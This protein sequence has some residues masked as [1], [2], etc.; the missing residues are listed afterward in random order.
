MIL[1]LTGDKVNLLIVRRLRLN[2]IIEKLAGCV[3]FNTAT[4]RI[5]CLGIYQIPKKTPVC[6]RVVPEPPWVV[7]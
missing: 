6:E 7:S 3:L 4:T 1:S 2:S 5:A